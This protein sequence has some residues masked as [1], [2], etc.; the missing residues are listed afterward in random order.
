MLDG[1]A[2]PAAMWTRRDAARLVTLLAL[3]PGRTMHREQVADNLWPDQDP[4]SLWP[5][6]HKAAYFARKA[7]GSETGVVLRDE[8]VSLLPEAEVEV[9]ARVFETAAAGVLENPGRPGADG[10]RSASEAAELY[11]GDLLPEELYDDWLAQVR[12]RLRL[13]QARLLRQARRWRDLVALDPADEEANIRLAH[14]LA[15]TGDHASALH[16]LDSYE[17][18]VVDV[19]GAAPGPA[20]AQL[21]ASIEAASSADPEALDVS[22]EHG[23][24]LPSS[25]ARLVGRDEELATAMRLLGESQLLTLVGPG[26][27]GKTTLA[28]EVARRHAETRSVAARF[29]DLTTLEQPQQVAPFVAQEIGVS[30]TGARDAR[31]VLLN[32]LRE[33]ELLLVLDN[34]EHV[35][36]AAAA[37]VSDVLRACPGVTVL[38]TSRARL[39]LAGERVLDVSTLRT[40]AADWSGKA[41]ADRTEAVRLFEQVAQ[42]VDHRYDP[43]QHLADVADIC[44]ALDGLPL[45]ITLAAGHVRTLPP[46]L[47]RQRLGSRLTTPGSGLRDGPERQS[48]VPATVRWSLQLLG[49]DETRLFA[50]MGVFSG[51]ADLELVEAVCG[52]DLDVVD[53]LARLVDQSLVLRVDGTVPRFTMLALVRE[54]ARRL[55]ADQRQA[56]V[57]TRYCGAVADRLTAIEQERWTSTSNLWVEEALA[58]VPEVRRGFAIGRAASD[59]AT[60]ARIVFGLAVL[61]HRDG[62][63]LEGREW[64]EELLEHDAELDPHE[65]AGARIAAGFVMFMGEHVRARVLWEEAADLFDELGAVRYAAYAR[66]LASGTW[67]GDIEGYEDAMRTCR[68]SLRV[69][70]ELGELPLI[71]MSLNVVGELARVRG[72][73][74]VAFEAYTEGLAV[75]ERS[76]DEGHRTVFLANLAYLAEH[77]GD[78]VEAH[79]LQREAIRECRRLARWM[80]LAWTISEMA[81]PEVALGRPERAALLL[82][83]AEAALSGLGGARQPGDVHEH[84]A[85][86]QRVRAALSD[87]RFAEL[88]A[89]GARMSLEEAADLALS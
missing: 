20:V 23:T 56:E 63:R 86:V 5:R 60:C 45:A 80:M 36:D 42:A 6:L 24:P 26:G 31:A 34:A 14:E 27:V 58:L 39:R 18:H 35:V 22:V 72:E 43:D 25:V 44:R 7:L 8:R 3:A 32:R 54:E 84:E 21:R 40:P 1:R 71:A 37:I 51:P 41:L 53:T 74:D 19:L 78:Y 17:H 67:V 4:T 69:A 83:A 73:D 61:W 79:R 59:W 28:V 46:R 66:C 70:R 9:D 12:D 89:Q 77:R 47:L 68:D 81:G 62:S 87:R 15:L 64:V 82:G 65:R 55:L 13:L 48:T 85:V 49:A 57:E 33:R 29:V 76:G 11:A 88:T 75:T 50:R 38:A 10:L 2:V 52:G 30:T 16:Q